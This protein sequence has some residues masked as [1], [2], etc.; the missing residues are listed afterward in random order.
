LKVSEICQQAILQ[1]FLPTLNK[2]DAIW[3]DCLELRWWNFGEES[4]KAH[5]VIV[6][7][8]KL[9]NDRR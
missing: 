8:A 9:V 3:R 6:Q 7:W 1:Q 5:H 4:S 2:L